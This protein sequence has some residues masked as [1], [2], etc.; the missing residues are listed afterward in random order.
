MMNS[1]SFLALSISSDQC[2][3]LTCMPLQYGTSTL[4][5]KWKTGQ[6]A[7]ILCCAGIHYRTSQKL[8]S[9]RQAPFDILFTQEVCLG[10][11]F[12]HLWRMGNPK[13]CSL[14]QRTQKVFSREIYDLGKRQLYGIFLLKVV[15]QN[16]CSE[17]IDRSLSFPM[18]FEELLWSFKRPSAPIIILL[19]STLQYT[20]QSFYHKYIWSKPCTKTMQLLHFCLATNKTRVRNIFDA[21]SQYY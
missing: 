13:L 17:A 9:A 21:L 20:Q 4:C 7:I 18:L 8:I 16:K 15:T 3:S 6:Q 19:F 5:N 1:V 10:I 2:A 11:N 14:Y 12:V